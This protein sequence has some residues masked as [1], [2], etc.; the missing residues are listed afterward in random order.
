MSI[1]KKVDIGFN[2]KVRASWL[3]ETLRLTAA[4]VAVNEIETSLKE[5]IAL[6]NQGKET[7]R[8]VFIYL[9]RVWIQPPDY[10]MA[11]RDEALEMFRH[12]PDADSAFLL[13]WGMCLAAYPFIAHVAESTGRLLRLQGE[14][15][16]AQVNVRIREQFGDR[17]F[18]YRSVRYNLSTF[19]ESGALQEG[20]KPGIYLHGQVMKPR[21]AKEM[22]WIVEALLHSQD[23]ANLSLPQIL[24]HGA[25]FPIDLSLLNL[26]TLKANIR[27]EIFRHSLTENLIGLRYR[28]DKSQF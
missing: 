2:R 24:V 26:A 15:Q 6:E 21:D 9:N 12:R 18:V 23:E 11:L 17:H 16:A 7:V 20:K 5:Q 3:T 8:K 4:G 1:R 10:C 22:G 13:N 19:L 27:L 25:L 14:A 28:D